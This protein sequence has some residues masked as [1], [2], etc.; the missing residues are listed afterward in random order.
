MQGYHPAGIDS[1]KRRKTGAGGRK[2]DPRQMQQMQQMQRNPQYMRQ[3]QQ[4]GGYPQPGYG[5]PRPPQI[6][7]PLV[8][9]GSKSVEDQTLINTFSIA[10]VRVPR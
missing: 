3:M 2:P 5:Y 1:N 8:S 10:E 4:R 7:M 6:L 9:Q